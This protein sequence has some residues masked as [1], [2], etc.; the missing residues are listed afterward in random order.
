LNRNLLFPFLFLLGL[1]LLAVDHTGHSLGDRLFLGLGVEPW[2]GEHKSGAHLSAIVGIALLMLGMMCT[3]TYYKPKIPSIFAWCLLV[4]IGVYGLFPLM[5]EKTMFVLK[6]GAN[7]ANSVDYSVKHNSCHF[8][9]EEESET[10]RIHA[11]CNVKVFNYGNA[12]HVQIRPL[13]PYYYEVNDF[14]PVT[15]AIPPHS[16]VTVEFEL[17][18]EPGDTADFSGWIEN[19]EFELLPAK[20]EEHEAA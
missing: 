6:Q 13:F 7:G 5:S 1:F 8:Q 15:I 12:D 9:P 19:M 2:T 20:P 16:T 18:N 11:F 10:N 3:V 4:C 17:W 14:A